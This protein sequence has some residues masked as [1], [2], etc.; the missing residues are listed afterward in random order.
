MLVH[1]FVNGST[2]SAAG[3]RASR[4]ARELHQRGA[5]TRLIVRDS[6]RLGAIRSMVDAALRER[7]DAIYCMDFAVAP[8]LATCLSRRA[9]RVVID[10][11]DAPSEFLELIEAPIASRIAMRGIERLGYWRANAMVVRG[12]HHRAM[13]ERAGVRCEIHIVEDGV[14]LEPMAQADGVAIRQRLGLHDEFVVGLQGNFTWYDQLGGGMGWE[15]V[16]ALADAG[17]PNWRALFIGEGPGIARLTDLAVELGVEQQLICTGKVALAELPS[18]LN[19]VDVAV[20][21]QTNDPSSWVRTTGKLPC[22]LACGK[23]VVASRVGTAASLLPETML[24]DYDGHWDRGYPQRL[25]E[26]LGWWSEAG[27]A[28]DAAGAMRELAQRFDY[29]T[30]AKRAATIAVRGLGLIR[31]ESAASAASTASASSTSGTESSAI[32]ASQLVPAT[33]AAAPMPS[34]TGLD[35]SAQSRVD[36]SERAA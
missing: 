36:R 22:Y 26:R 32:T 25:A 19:V 12:I 4:I 2:T 18:Y 15:V 24:V 23:P 11:G 3:E 34:S 1:F 33:K 35:V 14:D 17:Q 10:T 9:T 5:V 20:L 29:P 31:P 13:L 30:I 8:V 16:R 7:P 28:K 21:T 6:S 27:R